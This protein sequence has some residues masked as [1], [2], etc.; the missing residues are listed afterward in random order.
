[1]K[2]RR[3]SAA[4]IGR[5]A[6]DVLVDSFQGLNTTAPYTQLKN[7]VSP[8]Y[9]NVRLYAR[10]STDRR[11]A[12][13]TRKGPGFY[14]VPLG[15]TV[16]QQQTSVTGASD[17]TITETTW[18]GKKFTA[19]ATG[20]LTKVEVNI[21]QGTT[22]TQHLMVA[23]YS[24]SSGDPGSLLGT[25]SIL[26]GD[27]T[28]SYDYEVARFIEAPSIVSGTAYWIVCYQQQGGSGNWM[29][30]TTTNASTAKTSTNSGG[31]WSAASVDLNAKTYI[32]TGTK[33]LG[34]FRYT[35]SSGTNVTVV[36]HGTSLYSVNDITGATTVIET[37]LSASATDYWFDQA[38]DKLFYTNG[39]DAPRFWNGTTVTALTS[40]MNTGKFA[41]F[42]KN[43][44]FV[45]DPTDP[46]KIKFTDLGDYE[47][48][49]STNFIYAP[50]PKSGDPI[51]G[52][53]VFQDNLLVFTRK[54][55]YVLYGDDPGNFVLRQSSGKRGAVNQAVIQSDPN[56]VY[57]LSDDG[58]YRYNGSADELMSDSIQTEIDSMNDKTKA[59]AVVH[60][61]Y[62][63]L[64]YPG[65][66]SAV[67]NSAILWDTLN[68]FWLRDSGTYIY[69]PFVTEDN[70]L[71]EASSL[72]GQLFYAE[73]QYSDIGKPIDFVYWTKYF[74]DGLH[75]ILLRRLLPSIRLQTQPYDLDVM[76]DIDQRNTT[77]IS[78]TVSAQASGSTWGSGET[79]G[80]GE[81]WGSATVS[82]P[83]VMQGTEAF[84]H[85][86]RFEHSG[87]DTPVELLSYMLQIRVRRTE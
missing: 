66:T 52:I 64:Y 78:Y 82:S 75:K 36:A 73:Q 3:N 19:G 9:Y 2:I 21:K 30:S 32:S 10:N 35:P 67:A 61:N 69:R 55:K 71:V 34:G 54:T 23:I 13:G 20:R 60:N 49:Q 33:N 76:I 6:K 15:E 16:D 42:H 29:W 4:P 12:V 59:S 50:S 38:D 56:Y 43:R 11:V 58:V 17:Q 77:P 48:S 40:Y 72:V 63:R 22:P 86:I 70:T 51:T 80:G 39:Y 87:V 24:D 37:G 74:G 44:F 5:K 47:A 85:Q 28:T 53:R 79:W 84:W 46:T 31:T 27:T 25:S 7:G 65:A 81:T 62:Y 1:M 57:Y 8:Y 14:S 18:V 26:L 41:A 68:N 83:T 45:V